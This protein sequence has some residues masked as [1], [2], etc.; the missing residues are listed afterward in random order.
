MLFAVLGAYVSGSE[1]QYPD[2]SWKE[3]CGMLANLVADSGCNKSQF[4]NLVEAICRDFRIHDEGEL[5]KLVCW[6]KQGKNYANGK[7]GSHICYLAASW[8]QAKAGQKQGG[9]ERADS[10]MALPKV[11]HLLQSDRTI[12]QDG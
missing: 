10:E 12:H 6:Q 7:K 9:D 3:L 1:F 2:L 8:Y 11:H 4:T 5:Q